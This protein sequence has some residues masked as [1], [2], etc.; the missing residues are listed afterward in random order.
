MTRWQGG[1][2]E[3]P[4]IQT[5]EWVNA[6]TFSEPDLTTI[7]RTLVSNFRLIVGITLTGALIAFLVL[8]SMTPQ[9]TAST[10]IMLDSR[11]TILDETTSVFAGLPI[12]DTYIESEIELIRSDAIVHRVIEQMNLTSDPEFSVGKIPAGIAR[13]AEEQTAG[14]APAQGEALLVSVKA[15]QV[16]KELRQRLGVQRRGLSQGIVI[17][18][19]SRSQVKARDIANTFAE[20]YVSDQLHNKL[21]ASRRATEWL[22]AEL[23]KL[24]EETQASERAVEKYR[25]HN[26]LIG[27]GE[28]GVSTQQLRLLTAELAAAKVEQ[29]QSQV[30]LQQVRK[31]QREGKSPLLAPEI[32][33]KRSI[34]LLRSALGEADRTVE[35]FAS[36]YNV[37]SIDSI[38][39]F[40]EAVARQ[41]AIKKSL[42]VEANGAVLEIESQAASASAMVASL[43]SDLRRLRE[44]SAEVNS[45]SVGLNEL[46]REAEGKRRR[47]EALLAEFNEADNAAA[48]QTPHARIVSSAELPLSPSAP[49]KKA[50]FAAAIIFSAAL[51][52]FAA[53]LREFF[54]RSI[55]TPEEFQAA[56]NMRAVAAMP[57]VKAR[58]SDIAKAMNI[59]V[60]SPNAPYAEAIRSLRAELSLGRHDGACNVVAVTSPG[61]SAGKSAMA[62][63]LA[64]SMALANIKTLLVDADLRRPEIMPQ[65]Y[66]N[67]SH[68]DFAD[69]LVWRG[70]LARWHS[71]FT[72]PA[73]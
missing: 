17:S 51:G 33:E 58:R 29:S 53:L 14:A 2:V 19:R 62:A 59:I 44:E 49:R 57:A 21:N 68:M 13:L 73:A 8:K 50:A 1:L 10:L 18:F 3:E 4:S 5:S 70:R 47:Y 61:D 67:H 64:R 28:Q 12:A 22:Q 24:G 52:I 48:V 66:K 46:E 23:S 69:V 27:E 42:T 55:R 6:S 63:S 45:A 56:T 40:Q 43:E 71:E 37:E 30:T 11:S 39:P 9:F 32:A 36:R 72:K 20:T 16:A 34:G 26:T 31:L 35:E 7:I 15:L 25:E 54:R 38:P 41:E 60:R 65:L